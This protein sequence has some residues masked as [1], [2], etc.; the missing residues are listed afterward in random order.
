MYD[1]YTTTCCLSDEGI[2]N[3]IYKLV[4][5]M[6]RAPHDLYYGYI[7]QRFNHLRCYFVYHGVDALKVTMP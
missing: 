3:P 7:I 2:H 1:K 5:Q 4:L 6:V